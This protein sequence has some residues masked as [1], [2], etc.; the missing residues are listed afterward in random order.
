MYK[1]LIILLPLI[2][3][4]QFGSFTLE[5]IDRIENNT[6]SQITMLDDIRLDTQTANTV[7][8]LD[9][10]KDLVSSSVTDT[11]L[12]YLSGVTSSIQT[13][14]DSK[15]STPIDA[16]TEITGVL[17]VANGGTNSST[18]LSNDF[19]IISSGGSIVEDSSVTTTELGYLDGVTSALQTQIDGKQ[20]LDS[21]LTAI[22]SLSGTGLLSRTGAATYS[23]RTVTGTTNEIDVANGNGVSG[24]PTIGISDD[25]V[26]PGSGAV[27]VPSGATGSRPGSPVNGMFRYN[28]TDNVFEGYQGG[29][30]AEVGGGGSLTVV[31]KSSSATLAISGEEIVLCD[32]ASGDVTLTLPAASGNSGVTYRIN[33]IDSSSNECVL[34]GN[35]SETIDGEATITMRGQYSSI[36]FSSNGTNWFS[37]KDYTQ[38]VVILKDIKGSAVTGGS[39]TA[40]SWNTRDLTNVFG[41]TTIVSL[42]SNQFTLSEGL[43]H[44][45]WGSPC[46]KC[47]DH[48]TRLQNTTDAVTIAYGQQLI[49]GTGDATSNISPGVAVTSFMG[50]KTFE[51]QHQPTSSSGATECFGRANNLG[52]GDSVYTTVVIRK[53]Q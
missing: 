48:Q 32:A 11:E 38:Q 40:S 25:P 31:T 50:T 51:I 23:E 49:A 30:W 44:I 18:A 15:A 10:D 45:T 7:P 42:S 36:Q 6:E 29:S 4:A 12:G 1:L 24:D 8:F 47:S 43:Y 22:S 53:L 35:A 37:I 19:V 2:A 13:Q 52:S 20:A 27:T 33:K 39:C 3:Y 46:F 26:L 41:A 16:A 21:D 17:P 5:K 14:L 34:D 28:T 9:G